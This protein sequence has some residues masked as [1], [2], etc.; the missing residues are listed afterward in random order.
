VTSLL[1]IALTLCAGP[2][3]NW[4]GPATVD[5]LAAVGSS[6]AGELPH[7]AVVRVIAPLPDGF[8]LGSGTLVGSSRHYGLVVTNWHV[9]HDASGLITVV[10]PDGF[11]SGARVL[12]TDRNWDLA[13]L[14]IWRPHVEPV[15]ISPFP[16]RPGDP[17][18]IAGYGAGWY[19]AATGR[20]VEYVAPGA[21]FPAEMVEL[22]AAARQG[23]S[24]GPI[25]NVRGEVAGVLFG[26]ALG[27]T[28]GSYGGRVRA[29]LGSV[30]DDL[31]RADPKGTMLAQSEPLR[32]VPN[33]SAAAGMPLV[34]SAPPRT[35]PTLPA[36]RPSLPVLTSIPSNPAPPSVPEVTSQP[37]RPPRQGA[38][39]QTA[40]P[41][42]AI[43][44]SSP[45]VASRVSPDAPRPRPADESVPPGPPGPTGNPPILRSDVAGPTP[46]ASLDWT[47]ILGTTMP[48][49]AKTILAGVGLLFVIVFALRTLI[50]L[51]TPTTKGV[52]RDRK[53]EPPKARRIARPRK[54]EETNV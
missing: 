8:S 7:P 36:S 49:Q 18:T 42:P 17:L 30:V 16:P 46:Q 44:T 32:G 31:E 15:P 14:A 38:P 50:A 51:Q 47:E 2:A 13:A 3:P 37:L 21:N 54:R 41:I 45:R 40:A 22:S 24:G 48:E 1:A 29:F 12:K 25:L 9:V 6:R 26:T 4:N 43:S 11:R 35:V 5:P 28:T 10:F 27:Q 52:G 20:C 39:H 23:D 53:S 34:Q 19:R 33:I